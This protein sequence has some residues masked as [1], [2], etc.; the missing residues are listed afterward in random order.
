MSQLR[1]SP[2]CTF[3]FFPRV[4]R[5]YCEPQALRISGKLSHTSP[6]LN[7]TSPDPMGENSRQSHDI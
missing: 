3:S 4:E 7:G 2:V 6:V 5:L 1:K